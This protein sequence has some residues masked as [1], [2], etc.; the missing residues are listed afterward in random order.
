MKKRAR[1][2]L[3]VFGPYSIR[4]RVVENNDAVLVIWREH[5]LRRQVSYPKTA[6][7]RRDAI[8]YARG[9]AEARQSGTKTSP[10]ITVRALWEAYQLDE[11][12]A[13]RDRSKQ[14][15]AEAWQRFEDYAGRH[16]IADDLDVPM[17]SGL[18]RALEKRLSTNTIRQTVNQVKR[19]YAFGQRASII[20]TNRAHLYKFK[21]AK[22]DRKES[23]AE[24]RRDEAKKIMAQLDPEKATQ[25][26]AFV[27]LSL[28]INQGVRQRS[29][30]NLKWADVNLQAGT[31][32]WV[33]Q[34]S[35]TG[36][37]FTQPLRPGT[38]H[39]LEVARR[40]QDRQEIRSPWVLPAGSSK[41]TRATY[42]PQTLWAAVRA[43]ED[44]AG[45][46]HKP[47]RA[48]H[49]FRRM[50]AGDIAKLTGNPMLA[51]Q[52]IGDRDPKQ[53]ERYVKKRADQMADAFR[54]LDRQESTESYTEAGNDAAITENGAIEGVAEDV[55]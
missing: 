43:A 29:A 55:E 25:W 14:L 12:P 23:P 18:R 50:L 36:E 24:Y 38:I 49:G 19:V 4:V 46:A 2:N 28:C 40:W 47:Y 34:F 6:N 39:A 13:L 9:Y 11:F 20:N 35:K 32:T 33:K 1:P 22:D 15:Y 3:A 41:S 45:I 53:L 31:V 48:A 26:R 5:G 7:G 37:E 10:R 51:L 8:A 30:L 52:S 54:E 16:F 27:A 17:M 44:A 21:V 42:S